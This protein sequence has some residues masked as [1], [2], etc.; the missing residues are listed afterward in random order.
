MYGIVIRE[1]DCT[2]ERHL[3]STKP[4]VNFRKHK[5]RTRNRKL[6]RSNTLAADCEHG[7]CRSQQNAVS[8]ETVV[9]SVQLK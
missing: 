9:G 3:K 2:F 7:T 6:P 1:F 5:A 4:T 8:I